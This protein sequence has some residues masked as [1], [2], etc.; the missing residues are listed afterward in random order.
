PVL[1]RDTATG[2]RAPARR[3]PACHNPESPIPNPGPQMLTITLPDGS[4]REFDHPVSVMDVAR[5]IGPGL[6][7]ATVAGK[8]DGRQ[9]DA[10]D[11]IERDAP[12]QI[13]TPKDAE[14]AEIIRHSTANL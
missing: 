7:K 11:L 4:Q 13:L 8:V 9:V 12:L 5:S 6:A 2:I 1:P 14:G 10:S 3:T